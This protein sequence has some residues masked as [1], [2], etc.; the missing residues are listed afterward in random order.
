MI[1]NMIMIISMKI[2]IMITNTR[3]TTMNIKI[4]VTLIRKIRNK[5][6]TWT[7]IITVEKKESKIKSKSKN[8][9]HTINIMAST[10]IIHM[11]MITIMPMTMLILTSIINKMRWKKLNKR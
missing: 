5:K 4:A 11:I 2:H 8:L 10:L 9:T 1:M 7:S 6:N 3:I